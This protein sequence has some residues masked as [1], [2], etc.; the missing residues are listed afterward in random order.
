MNSSDIGF[1][2]PQDFCKVC[3]CKERRT[4]GICPGENHPERFIKKLDP[5]LQEKACMA[6]LAQEGLEE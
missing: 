2:F 6:I 5:I 3:P 4:I 1:K